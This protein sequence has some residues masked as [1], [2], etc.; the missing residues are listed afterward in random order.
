[1]EVSGLPF[2]ASSASPNL[3]TSRKRVRWIDWRLKLWRANPVGMCVNGSMALKLF[4]AVIICG[5]S[6]RVSSFRDWRGGQS[7]KPKDQEKNYTL[8]ELPSAGCEWAGQWRCWPREAF[9]PAAFRF[10][11][12]F[13]LH[14]YSLYGYLLFPLLVFPTLT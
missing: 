3:G 12:L 4:A 14:F 5:P 6:T 9:L 13:A 8:L 2:A 11:Y 7:A 10:R 1:M